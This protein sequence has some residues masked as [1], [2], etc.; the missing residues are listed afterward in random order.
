MQ[1]ENKRIDLHV[2]SSFSDGT[3]APKNL[4]ALARQRNVAAIAITDHDTMAGIPEALDEGRNQ[5]VE[6]IPGIEIS[7]LH[8][9]TAMHMLGYGLNHEGPGLQ[10]GLT[11]LQ[12]A[13]H[14]RNKGII[15]KLNKMGIKINLAELT[16]P[17]GGQIGRPHIA[18]LLVKKG[19]VKTV[20]QAFFRYLKNNGPAF[21]D[22]YKLPAAEAI[23]LIKNA[24][25]LA[26]LAH[27]AGIDPTLSS[28]AV[29]LEDLKNLGLSGLELYHPKHSAK[30]RNILEKLGEDIGLLFSGGSDFHGDLNKDIKLGGN[31][32]FDHVPFELWQEIQKKLI[33]FTQLQVS[34]L[35]P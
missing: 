26:F 28:L 25:G 6:V 22:S 31:S 14:I 20:N 27:P 8:N 33:S 12:E 29:L 32:Q 10:E 5:E 4:V 18:S 30:T 3:L 17:S 19:V 13:R 7:A 15:A 23:S 35:K 16:R 9:G 11:A 21:V 2:H 24:G 34:H 1:T